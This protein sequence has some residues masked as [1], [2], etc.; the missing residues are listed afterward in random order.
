[1][2]NLVLLPATK[3]QWKEKADEAL[4]AHDYEEATSYYKAL[5]D[6][7]VHT[8]NI[9]V[10]LLACLMKLH[11]YEEAE[12]Y[13]EMFIDYHGA[14]YYFVFV[15]FHIMI[16]YEAQLFSKA[17]NVIQKTLAQENV[18]EDFVEKFQE[19]YSIC[20]ELSKPMEQALFTKIEQAIEAEQH[21]K[22]WYLLQEWIQLGFSSD[23]R[24][25]AH[26]NNSIV[27]PML[28]TKILEKLQVDQFDQLVSV[29]KF[30]SR[31]KVYPNQLLSI[32]EEMALDK[33]H[34]EAQSIEQDNPTLFAFVQE[35]MFQYCYIMFPF[36][37]ED[38]AI[39][40]LAEAFV[41]VSKRQLSLEEQETIFDAEMEIHMENIE[42]CSRLYAHITVT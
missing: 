26:L 31:R 10:N 15:E 19:I 14:D 11:Q 35:L 2:N 41:Q 37:M 6:H 1:M 36:S 40:K 3:K 18:P 29:E 13:C 8:Y 20:Y 21:Q 17:M 25:A 28:K 39:P 9:H 12:Q 38:G 27:H 34:M 22:Q 30:G 24:L 16:L 42:I 7:E 23:A 4:Q 33:L 5:V 32:Q